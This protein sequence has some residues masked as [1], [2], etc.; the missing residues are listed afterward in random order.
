MF[1]KWKLTSIFSY[2]CYSFICRYRQFLSHVV[3]SSCPHVQNV[4]DRMLVQFTMDSIFV[5]YVYFLVVIRVKWKVLTPFNFPKW[6]EYVSITIFL[7]MYVIFYLN[8]KENV[9]IQSYLVFYFS[10]AIKPFNNVYFRLQM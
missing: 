5:W 3:F 8:S 2:I 7:S 9:F 4:E 10:L 6:F 1:H